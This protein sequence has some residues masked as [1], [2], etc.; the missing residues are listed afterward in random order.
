MFFILKNSG[1]KI[2]GSHILVLNNRVIISCGFF[3]KFFNLP[4]SVTNEMFDF[5]VYFCL[6]ICGLPLPCQILYLRT[7]CFAITCS[8]FADILGPGKLFYFNTY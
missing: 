2:I 1:C 8:D 3:F 5:F 7:I 6:K 4:F